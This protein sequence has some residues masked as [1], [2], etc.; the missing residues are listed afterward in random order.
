MMVVSVNDGI[1]ARSATDEFHRICVTS[2]FGSVAQMRKRYD[3]VGTLLA[4]FVDEVLRIF[5]KILAHKTI[6][7][8]A[9]FVTQ[10]RNG[11]GC[12][13]GKTYISHIHFPITNYLISRVGVSACL[14]ILK[15][16]THHRS[17]QCLR[18]L[19]HLLHAVIQFVITQSYH[20]IAYI[21]HQL[22]N[23][24]TS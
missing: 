5:I 21:I 15:I 14:H 24:F 23:L 9:L 1:Q 16:R 3:I 4:S 17:I 18:K 12:R 11:A 20:I 8:I 6:K 19:K 10:T 2:S 7:R 13:G 22:N